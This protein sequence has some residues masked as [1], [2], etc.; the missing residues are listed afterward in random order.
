LNPWSRPVSH[1]I[2]VP[3]HEDEE[4]S[5]SVVQTVSEGINVSLLD[6]PEDNLDEGLE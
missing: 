5:T 1:Y 6:N 4:G 2:R 3:V